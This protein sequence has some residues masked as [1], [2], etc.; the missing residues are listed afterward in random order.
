MN[1]PYFIQKERCGAWHEVTYPLFPEGS[2]NDYF[3]TEWFNYY[4]SIKG[5][6]IDT[7]SG[8]SLFPIKIDNIP[9]INRDHLHV[10]TAQSQKL[11]E[12]PAPASFQVR[13]WK[14]A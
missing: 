7:S 10:T 3:H 12:A 4:H 6:T 13:S 11:S 5:R 9:P 8:E 2:E 1:L 14:P